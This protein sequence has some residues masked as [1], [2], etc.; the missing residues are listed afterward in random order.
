M[1]LLRPYEDFMSRTIA[2]LSTRVAQL[3]FMHE[4]WDG[5]CYNH[6]GM[7]S[8][9]GDDAA[10]QAMRQAHDRIVKEIIRS[11]INELCGDLQDFPSGSKRA[12]VQKSFGAPTAAHLDLVV[13]T[14]EFIRKR[15]AA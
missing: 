14:L 6:W 3:R 1:R 2:S 9:F 12:E 7:S 4:I 10:Q 5:A 8:T 15:Q 11:P 13:R